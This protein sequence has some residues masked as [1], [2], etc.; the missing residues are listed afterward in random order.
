M[1]VPFLLCLF[2]DQI[3]LMLAVIP[4]YVPLLGQQGFD[5]TWF[6]LLFLINIA[7][8][9]LTPHFGYTISTFKGVQPNISMT[10]IY[11]NSWPFVFIFLISMVLLAVFPGLVTWLLKTL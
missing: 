7:L 8:G 11:N 1:D 6:W 4:I 3:A 2:I 9:G 10:V 5:S